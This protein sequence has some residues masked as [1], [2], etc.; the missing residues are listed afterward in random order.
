[1]SMRAF[2]KAFSDRASS[3]YWPLIKFGKFTVK[4]ISFALLLT[5]MGHHYAQAFESTS[6]LAIASLTDPAKLAPALARLMAG[7]WKKGAIPEKWDG[8]A[9]ERIVAAL[10]KQLG[11]DSN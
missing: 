2:N 3:P 9:A 7:Q 6:A 8:L 10:E 5:A 1:M 4:G 11:S